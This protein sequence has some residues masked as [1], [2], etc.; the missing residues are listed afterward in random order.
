MSAEVWYLDSSAIVKL[1]LPEPE[2]EAL[3]VWARSAGPLASCGLARVE[4][5]RAVSL[6]DAARSD[7]ARVIVDTLFLLVLDDQVYRSAQGLQ[8]AH[9]RSLDAIH[10]ASALLL[11]EDLA[12]VVTYDAR[13]AAGAQALGLDVLAP[14]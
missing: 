5:V 1:V 9:L 10:L 11:G 7:A 14:S 12:G 8:P 13:M 4:V 2:S 6:V 3:N